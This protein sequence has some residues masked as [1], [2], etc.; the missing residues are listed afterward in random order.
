MF[1]TSSH[2]Y[3]YISTVPSPPPGVIN[4][5]RNLLIPLAVLAVMPECL[6]R[7]SIKDYG[8]PLEDCGND[9]HAAIIM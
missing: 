4:G 3:S 2:K 1:K 8:F 6:C 5:V 9:D 7:A